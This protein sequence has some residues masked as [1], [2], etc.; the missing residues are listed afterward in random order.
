MSF[1]SLGVSVGLVN[2]LQKQNFSDPFPIQQEAIPTI[3]NGKDLLGIAQTGSGKTAS[4]VLPTLM[5]IEKSA[6]A[7]NRCIKLLVMVPTRELA[8]Q[9]H[10]AYQTFG[11]GVSRRIKSMA[12][13]GGV[14]INPQMI[15]L[16]NVEILIATPGRLLDLIEHNALSL[17]DLSVFIM[18]EA[19]KL[20]GK[21][22]AEEVGRIL[23]RLPRRRQNLLFSATLTD[24]VEN[25]KQIALKDPVIVKIQ[26]NEISIDLIQQEGYSVTDDRKG[27]LLRYLIKSQNMG[28]VLVF[29]SS[30]TK[31]DKVSNKLYKNGVPAKSIH[32]KLSQGARMEALQLFK[33][34]KLQVLVATDILSR[35][36]DIE[37]LPFVIN[38]EL[39]RSPKDFI[40]RIGRTGR[41]G[42]SGKAISFVTESDE[43]HFNIIQKKINQWV[44]LIDTADYDLHGY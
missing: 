27:P 42:S 19:D 33:T 20:L 30:V 22:F 3:L 41:A 17:S 43:H 4:Y 24:Q 36:I 35:G 5:A 23:K 1:E 21:G 13:Y 32:S 44:N 31:A 38:Y 14:S 34:G 18:D 2:I 26:S 16:Q 29:T 28:Q 9:V 12:V 25:F 40:H 37:F 39:P 15:G 8:I 6:P 10:Q 7:K 11:Q